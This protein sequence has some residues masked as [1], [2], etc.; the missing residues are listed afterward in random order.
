MVAER[1][2]DS[3]AKD[4]LSIRNSNNDIWTLD[5]HGLHKTEAVQALKERLRKLE[6]HVPS[7][8]SV[9]PKRLHR[10]HQKNGV[11]R[12]SSV[13]CLP[14]INKEKLDKP[15][16]GQRPLSLQVITGTLPSFLLCLV[17]HYSPYVQL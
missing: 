1:L 12:S 11:A 14:S 9:S 17:E 7:N 4:I 15:Q 8:R 2:N 5:L 16:S 13:E 10:I 3:A 6:S